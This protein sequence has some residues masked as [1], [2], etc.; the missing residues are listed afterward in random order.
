MVRGYRFGAS[1]VV[2]F[3]ASVIRRGQRT[4]SGSGIVFL[5]TPV[6]HAR[7]I[8]PAFLSLFLFELAA[9]RVRR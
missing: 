6:L 4:V 1:R 5:V 7:R 8:Q 9:V 3:K 2:T